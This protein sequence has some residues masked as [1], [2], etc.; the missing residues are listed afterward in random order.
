MPM[1]RTA[2]H[3]ECDSNIIK[4][5]VGGVRYMTTYTTLSVAGKNAI[6]ALIDNVQAGLVSTTMDEDGYIFLDRCGFTFASVL[7]YL[8]SGT[9][10]PTPTVSREQVL[11]ELDYF[12][13]NLQED[14]AHDAPGCQRIYQDRLII[15]DL[16]RPTIKE[17]EEKFVCAMRLALADGENCLDIIPAISHSLEPH[18]IEFRRECGFNKLFGSQ[19]RDELFLDELC[20][21]LETVFG[22]PVTFGVKELRNLADGTRAKVITVHLSHFLLHQRKTKCR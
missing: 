12:S 10:T 5:N 14:V 13:I 9:I 7:A 20:V 19:V 2:E 8:R 16:L 21:Q 17:N 22:C 6:T 18:K 1:R 4:L 15:R 11:V 3:L